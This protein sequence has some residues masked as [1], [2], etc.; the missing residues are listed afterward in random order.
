MFSKK[1]R[2]KNDINNNWS[3]LLENYKS[4]LLD[5]N[6]IWLKLCFASYFEIEALRNDYY[7]GIVVENES[8]EQINQYILSTRKFKLVVG[9]TM[10]NK[11]PIYYD[12][13]KDGLVWQLL[14]ENWLRLTDKTQK[15]D[16]NYWQY[17]SRRIFAKS[18][19]QLNGGLINHLRISKAKWIEGL[20]VDVLQKNE[21]HKSMEH[22]YQTTIQWYV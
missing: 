18:G 14:T 3:W 12:I 10:E 7:N 11:D 1:F 5:E 9:K 15:R 20:N 13:P 4:W 2:K 19:I 6:D 21:M 22:S 17:N 16:D 8:N